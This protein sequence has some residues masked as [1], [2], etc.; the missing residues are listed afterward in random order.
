MAFSRQDIHNRP[1]RL[2]A[3]GQ[4]LHQS[5]KLDKEIVAPRLEFPG[6]TRRRLLFLRPG[7]TTAHW[8]RP[9]ASSISANFQREFPQSGLAYFITFAI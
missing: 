1:R 8:R 2:L 3:S 4:Y 6:S 7:N 5:E 9:K